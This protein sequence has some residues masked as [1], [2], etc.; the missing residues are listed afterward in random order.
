MSF[1]S[2][3]LRTA[4]HGAILHVQ[5]SLNVLTPPTL[6]R[7][8]TEVEVSNGNGFI[9]SGQHALDLLTFNQGVDP[10]RR[11]RWVPSL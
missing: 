7:R 10:E 3:R 4:K 2:C 1:P 5:I 6:G 8:S 11:T 9:K